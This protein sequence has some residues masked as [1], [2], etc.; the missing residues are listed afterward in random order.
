[1]YGTEGE[2]D[3]LTELRRQS[4]EF[5]EAEGTTIFIEYSSREQGAVQRVSG[6]C[7]GLLLSFYLYARLH[8]DGLKIHETEQKSPIKKLSV[9]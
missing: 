2:H 1:M 9:L 3:I 4:S 5:K 8:M 7:I 6:I